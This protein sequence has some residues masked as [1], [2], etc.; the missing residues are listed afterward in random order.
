MRVHLTANA[1]RQQ[2]DMVRLVFYQNY[3]GEGT[4]ER[5]GGG[6]NMETQAHPVRRPFQNGLCLNFIWT[7]DH[8]G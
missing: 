8:V 4:E 7:E 5:F 3:S 2:N 6:L 1:F